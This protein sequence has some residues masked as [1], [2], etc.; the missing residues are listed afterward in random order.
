VRDELV[1]REIS[2]GDYVLTGG[3][4]PAMVLV[5]AVARHIPGVVGDFRSVERDSFYNCLLDHP[6]Y[7]RPRSFRGLEVPEA[8]LSGDHAR[9][10]RWRREQSLLATA[11]LRPDLLERCELDEPGRRALARLRQDGKVGV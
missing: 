11:R 4:L 2:I 9:I 10:E 5:D 1:E 8:L 6:H 3:E 7:T